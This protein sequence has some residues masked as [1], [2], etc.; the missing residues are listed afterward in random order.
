[1]IYARASNWLFQL[2]PSRLAISSKGPGKKINGGH[3]CT[4]PIS[5]KLYTFARTKATAFITINMPANI[6]QKNEITIASALFPCQVL[7]HFLQKS[8]FK[9]KSAI[10]KIM[11][12][13]AINT[14][15]I[16]NESMALEYRRL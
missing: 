13:G 3:T 14:S 16:M 11:I 2:Y 12:A 6:K 5:P 1:M 10:A 7:S 9:I 8:F 4:Q 15:E